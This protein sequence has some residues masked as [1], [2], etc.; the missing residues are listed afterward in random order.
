VAVN[1]KGDIFVGIS[2]GC[3]GGTF[4]RGVLRSK[5]DG[6][7]WTPASNAALMQSS[8]L[9][10]AINSKGHLFAGSG[11]PSDPFDPTQGRI[12]RSMDD[13]DSWVELNTDSISSHIRSIALTASDDLFAVAYNDAVNASDDGLFRSTDNGESWVRLNLGKAVPYAISAMA[14]DRS[15]G[16]IFIMLQRIGILRSVDNG[17]SWQTYNGTVPAN[18]VI[19]V[20]HNGNLFAGVADGRPFEP[21]RGVILFRENGATWQTV[22]SGLTSLIVEALGISPGDVLYA[23]TI[24]NGVFRSAK[25]ICIQLAQPCAPP[26]R[27]AV[28]K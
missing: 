21:N 20:A 11:S 4:Q 10:L 3:G 18:I 8:I 6:R 9:S 5:D 14:V 15:N 28:R 16:H 22:N 19:L 25:P 13:G 2:P 26:R 7:N 17:D 12:F 1:P 24:A 23:G 27:R